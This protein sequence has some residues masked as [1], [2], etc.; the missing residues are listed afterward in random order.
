MSRITGLTLFVLTSLVASSA[1]VDPGCIRN[2]ECGTGFDCKNA[3]CVS[4]TDAGVS[5]AKA[6][7]GGSSADGGQLDASG[8][9]AKM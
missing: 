2:S 9:A 5:T 7:E 1:C 3:R 4:T 8:D 6:G